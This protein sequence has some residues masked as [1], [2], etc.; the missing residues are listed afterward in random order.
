MTERPDTAKSLAKLKDFQRRSV[1]YVFRRLYTDED[2]VHRF[3]LA[4]EVGL[5]KTLVARGVTA[6]AVDHLWDSVEQIDVV[7]ICS[8]ADIARQNISRLRLEGQE[9]FNFASRL[10]MLPIHTRDLSGNK[11]N[12]V[13]F[14]PAT[15][16]DMGS[17]S[18]IRDE[19]ALL[20]CLLQQAWGIDGK[21]PINLL[22]GSMGKD[23][24]RRY[25]DEFQ[26][27]HG[28]SIDQNSTKSFLAALKGRRDL[29]R[30]FDEL[31][32]R[33]SRSRENIPEADRRDRNALLGELRRL[34]ARSCLQTLQPDLIILDEFQRFRN[35]LSGEDEVAELARELFD[36]CGEAGDRA[37]VLLLSATPYKMYTQS[38]DIEDDHYRDFL[39][40]ARFLMPGAGEAEA[41][42]KDLRAF[43]AAMCIGKGATPT[44]IAGPREAIERRLR[45]V[46]CRTERLGV[47]SDRSG[48]LQ[49]VKSAADGFSAAE[50][51]SFAWI[52]RTAAAVGAADSVEYWKAGAYLLNFM[53]DYALKK[54]VREAIADGDRALLAALRDPEADLLRR[55]TIQ[56][57]EPLPIANSRLRSLLADSLDKGA[58]KLLWM[59]PSLP[60]YEPRGAYADPELVGFTKSLIFSAWQLAPKVI[61]VLGSYEAERRMVASGRGEYVY[62]GLR[63]QQG[64]LLRIAND[65]ERQAGMS[66]FTLL[67][68][69][70][71]LAHNVDPLALARD[72]SVD[73]QLP[74]AESVLAAAVA[75]VRELLKPV[76][77][78]VEV[79]GPVDERW[80][81]AAPL[82]LDRIHNPDMRYWLENPGAAAWRK[83]GGNADTAF[84]QHVD[85]ATST[86]AGFRELGAP[87]ADLADVVASMAL[88]SPAIVALRSLIRQRPIDLMR[89]LTI[90]R[91]QCDDSQDAMCRLMD[92]LPLPS[93]AAKIALGFRAMFN[94][95]ESI[96]LLRG[97]D[98]R[99]AYWRRVLDY[100]V[101]GNLQSVM[102]EYLHMEADSMGGDLMEFAGRIHDAV[103]LRTT[104]LTH[105]EIVTGRGRSASTI[106]HGMRCHY[107]LR[108]GEGKNEEGDGVTREGQVRNAFN[109]PFRPFVLAST[110]VGQ[111]G[112]DFH[113]YCRAVYHWNLP[114]NPVDMEQREGRVHR[115]KGHVIRQNL[116]AAHGLGATAGHRDPWAA[117]FQRA[118]AG[119]EDAQSDLVPFWVFEG[120][121][122]IERR[123]PLFP[124]SREVTRYEDLKRS[125]ALYRL[126]FGQPRQEELLK[127]LAD[128]V[129]GTNSGRDL[130]QYQI[131]LSPPDSDS[132]GGAQS[133]GVGLTI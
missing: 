120:P 56:A 112:L 96:I 58:W 48:M 60:Y 27:I 111:E 3:L 15:S 2:Q 42:E 125:M 117:L 43:R 75:R 39:Q 47:S 86:F 69:C 52:D 17:R 82:A 94:R 72:A 119:R 19:R 74:T 24:W 7:Y 11:L 32:G 77:A 133:G 68:P 116:A 110:S 9:S 53:D 115:F 76:L 1:D 12:F 31:C 70:W 105:D 66:T 81:W 21:A 73:G 8:N 30:R 34:L 131:D 26:A 88:A 108:F 98:T 50:A 87:P 45:R 16:F 41:F 132:R 44:D 49:E 109:S 64:P 5:G 22:Q 57:Y 84:A 6:R 33:F 122:K 20:Y 18:G 103:S 25:L 90:V 95:P 102:D 85:L 51:R 100:G 78:D 104:T 38:S 61:A 54:K 4:D 40:T 93:A 13:S 91:E 101:D 126:V 67:Y 36:Y 55:E 37:R 128:R 89:L 62:E 23:S 107:A 65:G 10:T 71:T 124:F 63:E 106:Q 113:P 97:Q 121:W 14:T 80:Y 46:M 129:D 130:A 118:S 35:L 127:L 114:A 28:G 83:L 29:R 92:D 79:D 59:P 123:V 99:D